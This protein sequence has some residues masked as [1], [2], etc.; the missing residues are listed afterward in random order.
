MRGQPLVKRAAASARRRASRASSTGPSRAGRSRCSPRPR[1]TSAAPRRRRFAAAGRPAE[2]RRIP[3]DAERRAQPRQHAWRVLQH[4]VARRS[5]AAHGRAG[6]PRARRFRLGARGRY[7]RT[8]RPRACGDRRRSSAPGSR[9][10]KAW[11][12]PANRRSRSARS[13]GATCASGTRS[14]RRRAPGRAASRTRLPV[15]IHRGD[16]LVAHRMAAPR[17]FRNAP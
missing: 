3:G 6:R 1:R 13:C 16:H 5:P 11:V 12:K 4:V 9:I 8:R 14:A 2:H 17:A 10:R 15:A 7:P